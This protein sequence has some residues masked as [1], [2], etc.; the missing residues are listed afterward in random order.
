MINQ[1]KEYREKQHM[2]QRQLA[3]MCN[4]SSRSIIAIEKGD[5]NPCL[6]LAYKMSLV[7]NVP[8]EHLFCLEENIKEK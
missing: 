1:L 5:Y 8:M 7:L 4:V 2:T 3:Q 6:L